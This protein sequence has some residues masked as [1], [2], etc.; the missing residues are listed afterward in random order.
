MGSRRSATTRENCKSGHVLRLVL[1]DLPSYSGIREDIGYVV[2]GLNIGLKMQLFKEAPVD[3]MEPLL[4]TAQS[5]ALI[6]QPL[7]KSHVI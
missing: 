2:K 6:S 3:W 4:L 5:L 7:A 1:A